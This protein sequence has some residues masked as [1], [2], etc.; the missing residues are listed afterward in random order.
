MAVLAVAARAR[1][2]DGPQ[3]PAHT[4]AERKAPRLSYTQGPAE[5]LTEEGF[6][7]EVAVALDGADHFRAVAPDVLRVWFEKVPG[8]YRGTLEYTGPD[9]QKEPLKV[10]TYS[11]CEVLGRLVGTSASYYIPRRITPPAAGV[12]PP[13]SP[14][15][16]SPAA[17]PAHC[18][19]CDPSPPAP[20]PRKREP[21]PEDMDVTIG[22]TGFA[23]L[24]A[25][26]SAN[27]GPGAGLMVDVRADMFSGG[28]ELR[29]IFPSVVHARDPIY[30]DDPTKETREQELDLSQISV[31]LVPCARWKYLVGCGVA[32]LGAT[33]LKD[34]LEMTTV[35]TFALGPRVGVE[36]PITERFALFG[37][38]E[39]LFA[40]RGTGA[41]YSLDAPGAPAANVKW[42]QEIASG[43]FGLGLTATFK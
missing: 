21:P 25:G 7:S 41:V 38:G 36:V 2:Q 8:G 23:L 4:K 16:P 11:N 43:F 14:L 19:A 32:Q 10:Q 42:R 15:S 3:E 37:F 5:C 35:A 40:V 31:A 30:P 20:P 12:P 29:G 9:A 22:L 17:V 34:T 18:S 33:F 39:V 1:A 27:V 6:R 26:F 24:T 13:P 28:L